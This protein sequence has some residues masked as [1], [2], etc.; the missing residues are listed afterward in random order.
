[1]DHKYLKADRD[2]RA[3][4]QALGLEYEPQ[5]WGIVN[6]NG[7]RLLEFMEHLETAELTSTQR[8]ELAELILASANERLANPNESLT[9]ELKRFIH[10]NMPLFQSHLEYWRNLQNE[11]EAP[12]APCLMI[13][14]P[15]DE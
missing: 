10:R 9:E 2:L 7:E 1:M 14:L 6:A 5:D 8:F 3:L 15:P 12:I 4:S 13:H 11:A